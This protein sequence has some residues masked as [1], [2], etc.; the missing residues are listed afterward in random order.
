MRKY[1]IL[2][3]NVSFKTNV[4]LDRP[5]YVLKN[6]YKYF[7][8]IYRQKY[9][10]HFQPFIVGGKNNNNNVNNNRGPSENGRNNGR[11]NGDVGQSGPAGPAP[12]LPGI[13]GLFGDG[14]PKLK[15]TG[16]NISNSIN[17]GKMFIFS[18]L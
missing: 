1:H 10:L 13:G 17:R 5:L 8:A 6:M 4:L 14:F 16:N 11:N 15:P 2:S 12:R 3:A 18:Y 9:N 7:S